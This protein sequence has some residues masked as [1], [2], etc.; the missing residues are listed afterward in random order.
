MWI[1]QLALKRPYTF[2]VAALLILLVSPLV[3]LQTPTD[4][5]PNINIPVIAVLWNFTGFSA[6]QMADRITSP[7]ERVL[8]TTVN[9]IDH[10]ESQS[11][12]DRDVVKIYFHQ[13]AKVDLAYSQVTSISQTMLHQLP[14]G[15][16]A[17]LILS[18][19]ASSVP[20]L[21]IGLSSDTLSEQELADWGLNI[22]R[23]QLV[24]VPGAGIPY[25][26]GG[27]MAQISVDLNLPAMQANHLSPEDVLT[28]LNSQNLILPGGTAKI[29]SLEYDVA[30]PGSPD[31]V[32]GLNDLPIRQVNGSTLYLRDVAHARR[33]FQIQTNIVRKDGH[34]GVL[35]PIMKTGN[36][37]TIDIVEGIKA[38]LPRVA[39][40]IP[41][42]L[43]MTPLFDQSIFVRAAV[44]GVIREAVIAACLTALMILLFLGSWRS[45]V[46]IAISIPLAILS[47]ILCL[48]ALGETINLMTLGGLALAVGMLVDDATVSIENIN[49][50]L[51]EGEPLNESIL[52]GSRQIAVPAFVSTLCICIVFIPM[53]LLS[54]VAR[55][56]FVPLAEAVVFAMIASYVLSRTL[57]PTLAMYLLGHDHAHTKPKKKDAPAAQQKKDRGP[58]FFKRIQVRFEELFTGLRD[59]YSGGL[60]SAL[61]R[62]YLFG[63]IFLGFCIASLLLVP[64]LG[65]DFFP[66]VDAGQMSLHV[67]AKTGLRIEDMAALCD[68]IETQIR[69]EIPEKELGVVID[70]IGL[71]YSSINTAYNNN[72]TVGPADAQIMISLNEGHHA[73]GGYVRKLRKD[74]PRDFPGTQFF[75]QPADIVT[76]ILNFGLPSP[77]DIQIAGRDQNGD[78]QVASDLSKQLAQV[79]GAVD[80]HL[81]QMYDLPHF[82]VQVNRTKASQLGFTEQDVTNSLLVALSGSGQ[83]APTFWL[84]PQN[85]VNYNLVAQMPD[86]SVDSLQTMQNI[87][88]TSATNPNVAPQILGNIATFVRSNIPGVVTHYNV[89]PTVDIYAANQDRD[90]GGVASDIQKLV[91]QAKKKLP[92]G[93][94]IA[95]KGQVE[96]M[97]AS[98]T[99][100][101]IGLVGA[102]V[103]V[104]LL[105]VVNFQSWIDPFIIITALPGALAGIVWM[106]F[107]TGTTLNVPSMMGSI[108]CIGVATANSILV[109]S[110]ANELLESRPELS[111]LDAAL[112]AGTTRLRPVLMTALAMI[113]GMV[114]MAFGLGEGGEQNAPLARAVIGGLLFATIA[115]LFFV[116]VVFTVIRTGR[117]RKP[118]EDNEGDESA[119]PGDEKKFPPDHLKLKD[120]EPTLALPAPH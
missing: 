17:P 109:I 75:F 66:D 110:F 56:L 83:V 72:G 1:V 44:N 51:E 81:Q 5:F 48:S 101:G 52:E 86:Y 84:N 39:A 90:L 64:F 15:T 73:T 112:E 20:V 16:T 47:S 77:I 117:E 89:M 85:G 26:Y 115:T 50:H 22:I 61:R 14:T 62:P 96:T 78:A 28:A 104:Y 41:P 55:Y 46:I 29:G 63:A 8:T 107:V 76:Q 99:G 34:R 91:D 33:G 2:I 49:R 88:V 120:S 71:P 45:T 38:R 74:L 13:G 95:V 35:M 94:T 12:R 105:I 70:N 80:V 97:H 27:K 65:Q 79:P 60:G 19:N 10:I 53:F 67:R 30:I 43:K 6:Q 106:L 82:D 40:L 111:A 23:T 108:M 24:T 31:T 57:V 37:S 100:L 4:I 9:D 69:Q 11:L 93:S 118:R 114:P 92:H 18:Y 42:D 87:P 7:F 32:D 116:P 59:R 98:F 102:I 21:E 36:T 68:K 103:L 3:I 25:P 54:G 58:G 113:I 119:S